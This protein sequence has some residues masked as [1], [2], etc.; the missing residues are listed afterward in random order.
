MTKHFVLRPI[1][2]AC[3]FLQRR[4]LNQVVMEHIIHSLQGLHLRIGREVSHICECIVYV[5]MNCMNIIIIDI[6]LI[7]C[8]LNNIDINNAYFNSVPTQKSYESTR[9]MSSTKFNEYIITYYS[10]EEIIHTSMR[11]NIIHRHEIPL[12]LLLSE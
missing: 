11:N 8:G 3:C 1:I 4:L 9:K 12:S 7:V 2:F 5:G 6:R 10:H